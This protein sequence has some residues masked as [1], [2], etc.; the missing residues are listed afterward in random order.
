VELA[1]LTSMKLGGPARFFYEFDSA[2]DLMR[3]VKIAKNER[4]DIFVIGG[5]SN[6]VI[7]DQGVEALVLKSATSD[8]RIES[9][10][11]REAIVWAA[12]GSSW[13]DLVSFCVSNGLAG[14]EA[15]SGIPGTVGA[16]PIQNIG[17]YGQEFAEIFLDLEALNAQDCRVARFNRVEC[18]FSYRNSRF[19]PSSLVN[20]EWIILNLRLKL[21]KIGPLAIRYAELNEFLNT[22]APGWQLKSIASQLGLIRDAVLKI[23]S[24]KSMVMDASNPNTRSCGS[25]FTNPIIDTSEAERIQKLVLDRG[26]P[27]IP[28]FPAEAGK[29]KL[30]AARIVE[31]SGFTRGFVFG[32]AGVS[33]DHALALV[34]RGSRSHDVYELSKKIQAAAW[35]QLGIRLETEPAFIGKF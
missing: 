27:P 25:F 7:S 3:Q 26:L 12:A 21:S 24:R 1:P 29:I 23:R 28:Q 35:A 17:A 6:I 31:I 34:A 18:H 22:S 4:C 2:D 8:I 10:T 13:D 19:K 9:E 11:D 16:A 14:I 33:S 5:G 30:S 15:L 32:E 20:P